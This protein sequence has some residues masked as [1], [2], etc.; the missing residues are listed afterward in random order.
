MLQA[1]R[2]RAPVPFRFVAIPTGLWHSGLLPRAELSK[3]GQAAGTQPGAPTRSGLTMQKYSRGRPRATHLQGAQEQAWPPASLS[4]L[5][6]PK[7]K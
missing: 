1:R 3:A 5:G 6:H 4:Y 7:K 2:A